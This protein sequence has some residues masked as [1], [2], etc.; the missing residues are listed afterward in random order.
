[1]L[2]QSDQS[3]SYAQLYIYD[4][5]TALQERHRRNSHLRMDVLKSILDTLQ[6]YNPF[7]A[8]YRNAHELL[9][10]SELEGK[11]IPA[12]LHYINSANDR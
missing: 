12:Y 11:I 10:Q 1:M 5:N 4:P 2:P 6:Q 7:P 8:K 9:N 3:P